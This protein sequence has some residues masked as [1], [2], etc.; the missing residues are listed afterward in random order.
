MELEAIRLFEGL[1]PAAR[2]ELSRGV[3]RHFSPGEVLWRAGEPA[4][5][6]HIVIAGQ[7][8]VVRNS[9]G[10]QRVVHHETTGGTLGDVALFAG[11]AY[12]ATALA[13]TRVTTLALTADLVHAV[14]A[15]DPA[16]ALRLLRQLA[17]RV[18]QV[19]G[20]FDRVSSLSVP[21]RLARFLLERD[22]TG[23]GMGKGQTFSLG[24]TQ[25]EVAEE[26][27]TVREVIVRT[28]RELRSS[29][30][31]ESAGRGR[32]AVRDPVLLEQIAGGELQGHG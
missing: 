22:S 2:R 8:R 24:M 18:R 12:P 31:I 30:A 4:H 17:E 20:R 21:A 1:N 5:A 29:G 10:R 28:L 27:G 32:Y 13:A 11:S 6:L 25:Q 23:K 19:I 15:A 14:I 3:I 7:V 16:F 26:L 9:G